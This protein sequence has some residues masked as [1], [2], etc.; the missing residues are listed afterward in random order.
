MMKMIK[1][2]IYIHIPFCD[3][4]CSYCDFTTIIG[5]DKENYKKYLCLLL[6][7]IDLYKDPSVFVDTIY[8]GGGTPS[9]FPRRQMDL[10]TDLFLAA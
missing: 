3:K 10:C 9:L 1:K 8:I 2:G 4:K 6:Q 5:K 7:E